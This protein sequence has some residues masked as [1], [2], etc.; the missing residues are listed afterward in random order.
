MLKPVAAVA[1]DVI[2]QTQKGIV[3][4][5]VALPG[6]AALAADDAGRPLPRLAAARLVIAPDEVFLLSTANG[7]S[8]DSRYFGPLP[9]PVIR[10]LAI[11]VWV[12]A[13]GREFPW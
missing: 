7:R 9:L 1:G 13:P 3:L 8:F 10:G 5:G 4:N 6:T 2:E 11:P 12:A